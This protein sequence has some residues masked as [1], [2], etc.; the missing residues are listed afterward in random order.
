MGVTTIEWVSKM[1]SL[2]GNR[3]D[4]SK[5]EY[6]NS[7]TKVCIIC[8]EH[9]E[10]WQA[11]CNHNR[12]EGC[13]ECA[14]R[15]FN[16]DLRPKTTEEFLK[17][18]KYW[19]GDK[20]NY[21]KVVYKNSKSKVIIICPEHGEFQ[22][23]ASAHTRGQG[24]PLCRG[25]KGEESIASYLNINNIKFIP[26]YTISINENINQSGNAYI[27]F[28]LPELNIMIEFNGEQH[29]MPLKHF[30]GELNYNRQVVRDN[31]VKQYCLNNNIKLIE[32][33]Y[34]EDVWEILKKE[35]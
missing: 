20:Y 2:Y 16:P 8:S 30:G 14:K 27:D 5:V 18:A 28:F 31:Y 15:K 22:Q 10:F 25:S 34:D 17:D 4:Y 26:Q 6:I 7:K 21:S 13:P 1:K 32:I 33:R 9:G 12:Y 29:Y 24:C 23:I 11:P 19:H 35:L 3:Y